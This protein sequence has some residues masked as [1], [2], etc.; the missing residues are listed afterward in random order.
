MILMLVYCNGGDLQAHLD[1][2]PC[3]DDANIIELLTQLASAFGYMEQYCI[4][5]QDIKPANIMLHENGYAKVQYKLTGFGLARKLQIEDTAA[6]QPG[7]PCYMAPEIS[8][9]CAV[10]YVCACVPLPW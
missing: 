6:T 5:H 2:S 9:K 1:V 3:M 4:T 10:R 7:T 8:G